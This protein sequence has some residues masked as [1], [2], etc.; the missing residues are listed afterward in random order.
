MHVNGVITHMIDDTEWRFSHCVNQFRQAEFSNSCGNHLDR[1]PSLL[2]N[3][4][5]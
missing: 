2:P 1:S 3:I 5:L 4:N